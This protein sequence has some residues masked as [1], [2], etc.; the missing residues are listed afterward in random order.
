MIKQL[1]T[2]W[3]ALLVEWE[4]NTRLKAEKGVKLRDSRAAKFNDIKEEYSF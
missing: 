2:E 4:N 1:N 3:N